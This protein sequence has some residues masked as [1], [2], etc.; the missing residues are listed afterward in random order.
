[1]KLSW[2]CVLIEVGFLPS[3]QTGETPFRAWLR[4]PENSLDNLE[5]PQTCTLGVQGDPSGGPRSVRNDVSVGSRIC[6]P[7]RRGREDGSEG[8]LDGQGGAL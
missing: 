7:R 8:L 3:T 6:G 2:Q 4:H 5:S 1:M